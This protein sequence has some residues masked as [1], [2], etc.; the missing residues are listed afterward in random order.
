MLVSGRAGEGKTALVN[1]IREAA[2]TANLNILEESIEEVRACDPHLA[3]RL[4]KL[5]DV[6]DY[7]AILSLI[8]DKAS[9]QVLL[10]RKYNRT[11]GGT[12]RVARDK[13]RLEGLDPQS[14]A[15]RERTREGHFDKLQHP[16]PS[17]SPKK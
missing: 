2:M 7:G 4:R 10:Y 6:Y 1:E 17:L 15:I 5:L 11:E 16:H 12:S 9:G 13:Y 3:A 8:A 14:G